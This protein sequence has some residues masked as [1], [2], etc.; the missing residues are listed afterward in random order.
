[1]LLVILSMFNVFVWYATTEFSM[2]TVIGVAM[3]STIV[4]LAWVF[5]EIKNKGE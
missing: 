1:M 3:S 4:G 2:R 5:S